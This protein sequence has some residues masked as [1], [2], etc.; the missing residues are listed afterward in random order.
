MSSFK[1][2]T[3]TN[4]LPYQWATTDPRSVLC[5]CAALIPEA[6]HLMKHKRYA[7]DGTVQFHA[8]PPILGVGGLLGAGAYLPSAH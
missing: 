5:I 7:S 2:M 1:G 3:H 8:A 6:S 4:K